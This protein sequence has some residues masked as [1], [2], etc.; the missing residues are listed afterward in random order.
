[1]LLE[2]AARQAKIEQDQQ[3]A[4]LQRRIVEEQRR[5]AAEE[6]RRKAAEEQRRRRT[7]AVY[8][9]VEATFPKVQV[10]CAIPEPPIV[11]SKLSDLDALSYQLKYEGNNY[12]HVRKLIAGCF[13]AGHNAIC[14]G[15]ADEDEIIILGFRHGSTF[16]R[17]TKKI[18]T[19]FSGSPGA[20]SRQFQAI[21]QQL[22]SFT[23]KAFT[24]GLDDHVTMV[25]TA[26]NYSQDGQVNQGLL[27]NAADSFEKTGKT[28]VDPEHEAQINKLKT[29]L[30]GD[31]TNVTMEN[32]K[33]YPRDNIST[34]ATAEIFYKYQHEN[35]WYRKSSLSECV[36]HGGTRVM[37]FCQ[38]GNQT[39]NLFEVTVC[40][41][42]KILIWRDGDINNPE[43][44]RYQRLITR[45]FLNFSF[46]AVSSTADVQ[47][48]LRKLSGADACQFLFITNYG[49]GDG[50]DF[51]K[52][53]RSSGEKY[54]VADVLAFFRLD[55]HAKF[56][57]LKDVTTADVPSVS[58]PSFF[59]LHLIFLGADAN[60]ITS[61]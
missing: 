53:L 47:A 27:V 31:G 3:A 32:F 5:K 4:E 48:L 12:E 18:S 7:A 38:D 55:H 17:W 45:T 33:L 21:A 19:K 36:Q 39:R 35:Q 1:L 42:P 34:S 56:Q 58:V 41:K 52:N 13:G 16:V 59:R 61:N 26:L 29:R 14:P 37:C 15:G 20:L 40:P 60:S 8:Q 6:Q 46:H 44:L 9:L 24:F 50:V 22:A 25:S 10:E 30:L 28:S 57:A 23:K 49:N 54:A 2:E 51:I 43:N 11:E